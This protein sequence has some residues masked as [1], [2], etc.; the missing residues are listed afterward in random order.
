MHNTRPHTI[1]T[2]DGT[3]LAATLFAQWL[4]ARRHLVL[5]CDLRD[6]APC[7][8]NL[9]PLMLHLASTLLT[10]M[11]GYFPGKRLGMVGDLPPGV[12]RQWT[13]WCRTSPDVWSESCGFRYEFRS[14]LRKFHAGYRPK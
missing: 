9:V 2:P 1:T 13:R 14:C 11:F 5:T 7:T 8:R 10:P 6:W 12:I 4:S 3:Q